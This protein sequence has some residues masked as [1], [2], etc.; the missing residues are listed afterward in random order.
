MSLKVVDIV[1]A[2][3]THEINPRDQL[4]YAISTPNLAIAYSDRTTLP[5]NFTA[6][7]AVALDV[8]AD[9]QLSPDFAELA[10]KRTVLNDFVVRDASRSRP[11]KSPPL[12]VTE[13]AF[14]IDSAAFCCTAY[15]TTIIVAAVVLPSVVVLGLP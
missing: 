15:R 3:T 7:V 10:A 8:V 9:V 6:V 11:S 5:F 13:F 4:H 14:R 1:S 2:A 12:P